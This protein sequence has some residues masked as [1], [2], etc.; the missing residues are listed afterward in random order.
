MKLSLSAKLILGFIG[1]S[2]I[3][4]VIGLVGVASL[5]RI[6]TAD[7]SSYESGTQGLLI[8]LKA[9]EAFDAIKVATRDEALSVDDQENA[10]A[11]AAYREG[12]AKLKQAI[13]DYGA[14]VADA[15]DKANWEN[16]KNTAAIYFPY[17]Q[18]TIDLGVANKNAEAVALMHSA[19]V[20]KVRSDMVA[21]FQRVSDF[22]VK[23]TT[24]IYHSN[25]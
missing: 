10:R 5:D 16:L 3:G 4:A 12:L 9:T 25:L 20:T 7:I 8:M 24:D 22:N 1:V 17:T 13:A 6:R 21:A 23:Y 15:E 2:L 18:Q 19:V 11:A 14:T